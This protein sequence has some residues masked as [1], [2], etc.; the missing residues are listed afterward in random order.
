MGFDTHEQA[1][2]IR[3]G[4]HD[5]G[6]RGKPERAS[7]QQ[8]QGGGEHCQGGREAGGHFTCAEHRVGGRHAPMHQH[9]LV[10][11]QRA[12]V[13]RHHPVASFEHR[14]GDGCKAGFV[15]IPEGGRGKPQR[16]A[17]HG[18]QHHQPE[19]LAQESRQALG[20]RGG[21]C[22]GDY[23]IHWGDGGARHASGFSGAGG[24]EGPISS[25]SWAKSSFTRSITA[26]PG[27]NGWGRFTT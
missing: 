1:A 22:G 12:V 25:T 26:K 6:G 7:P 24:R 13:H 27:G 20:T 9:R 17:G 10:D 14:A 16:Q 4:S 18:G 5:S 11:R 21:W 15:L 23:F 2:D 8:R 19:W 3:Q